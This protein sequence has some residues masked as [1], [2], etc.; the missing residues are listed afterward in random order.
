MKRTIVILAAVL[1]AV[2]V[3]SCEI[4]NYDAPDGCLFGEIIDSETGEPIPLP[5]EGTNGAVISLME[6][7][8]G[9]TLAQSFYAKYDGSF[10]NSRIF[11]GKYTVTADGPF[12]AGQSYEV[13][14]EDETE[15]K[16]MARPFSR[17]EID[18]NVEGT[19]ITVNYKVVP[20]ADGAKITKVSVL[21]NYREQTDIITGNYCTAKT[22]FTGKAE[23]SSSFNMATESQYN[24]NIAKIKENGG[25]IYFR[26]AAEVS[27]KVNYSPVKEIIL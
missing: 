18:T 26:V 4:D 13:N 24:D 10:R 6:V 7:G 17:I 25:K 1:A 19:N 5:V 16:I 2:S 9:A 20:S 22:S 23:G 8:T 21:W 15:L 14:I 11:K 27:G 3:T 12:A